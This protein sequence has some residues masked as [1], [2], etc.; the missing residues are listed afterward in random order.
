MNSLGGERIFDKKPV[1]CVDPVM[2]F[3]QQCKWGWVKYPDWVE[4]HEDLENCTFESGCTL[5]LE[6]TKPTVEEIAEFNFFKTDH[7]I[8]NETMKEV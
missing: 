8:K 4:T 6:D 1:R 3:C 7:H 2:K 5:G